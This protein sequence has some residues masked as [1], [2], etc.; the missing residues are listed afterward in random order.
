LYYPE[1]NIGANLEL[2]Q[3]IQLKD[4]ENLKGMTASQKPDQKSD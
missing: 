4:A 3:H 1:V 2:G